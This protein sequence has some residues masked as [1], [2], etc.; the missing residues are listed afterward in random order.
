MDK[1]VSKDLAC[2]VTVKTDSLDGSTG[3]TRTVFAYPLKE[4][5]LV[6]NTDLEAARQQKESIS[7]EAEES[8]K[9]IST[10]YA[11]QL[12]NNP[13]FN[14]VS[15]DYPVQTVLASS[16]YNIYRACLVNHNIPLIDGDAIRKK[17]KN[18]VHH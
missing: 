3:R 11:F 12:Q 6:D 5:A 4:I 13:S 2:K 8:L 18:L 9:Q 1:N 17:K 7:A 16:D 15:G 10:K 14:S